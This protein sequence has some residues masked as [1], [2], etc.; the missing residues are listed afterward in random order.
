MDLHGDVDGVR[1]RARADLGQALLG[2]AGEV[3]VGDHVV[4]EVEE[5]GVLHNYI[6]ED[7][8]A[9]PSLVPRPTSR[10]TTP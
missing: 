1:A 7:A 4:C 6:V 5:V 8:D 3:V 10:A 2:A 9:P